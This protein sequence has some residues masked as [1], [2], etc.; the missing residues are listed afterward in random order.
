MFAKIRAL[1]P[2]MVV[3]AILAIGLIESAGQ[4]WH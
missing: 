3:L 4:K 2:T 1:W